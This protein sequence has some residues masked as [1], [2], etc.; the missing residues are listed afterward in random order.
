[1]VEYLFKTRGGHGTC[2]A[3]GQTGSGK[4]VTME[5]LGPTAPCAGNASGLYWYVAHEMFAHVA[6]EGS[7]GQRLVVRAGFFEIYRGKCFDLLA[8]KKVGHHVE[9][10]RAVRWIMARRQLPPCF[11]SV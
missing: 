10:E 2:F 11:E 5:G 9:L 4:T 1:M 8:R 7:R 6:S 3:Y